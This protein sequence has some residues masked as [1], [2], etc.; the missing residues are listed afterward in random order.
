[1]FDEASENE[2]RAPTLIH[3][4]PHSSNESPVAQSEAAWALITGSTSGIGLGYATV[5]LEQGFNVVLHGR[6]LSK[7]ERIRLDLLTRFSTRQIETLVID[8]EQAFSNVPSDNKGGLFDHLIRSRFKDY[9][10]TILINNLG[11]PG[12]LT[13]DF[14]LCTTHAARP[15][16]HNLAAINISIMF[17]L[18]ITRSCL[19]VLQHNSPSL[20]LNVGSA[21]G[22][23]AMP[24][25]GVHGAVKAFQEAFSQSLDAE[26][27][28]L[29]LQTK[30]QGLRFGIGAAKGVTVRYDLVGMCATPGAGGGG[31]KI[32]WIR[33]DGETYARSS[34]ALGSAAGR[35]VCWGYWPHG[36]LF[37]AVLGWALPRWIVD[38]VTANIV[39]GMVSQDETER[40]QKTALD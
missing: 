17:P 26:M 13:Q 3:S 1:M 28:Y 33:P 30:P 36:L 32:T 18:E 34:L 9:N 20:I 8:A 19:P 25:L 21:S 27:R 35:G 23:P 5:L 12:T 37:G 14:P 24:L 22:R 6:N 16:S 4:S 10:L 31:E 29:G 7:L 38:R 15:T 2:E 39:A 11:G 40:T